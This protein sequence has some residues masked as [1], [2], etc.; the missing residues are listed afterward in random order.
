V[1]Q[2]D[3]PL[4]GCAWL[5]MSV[6]TTFVLLILLLIVAVDMGWL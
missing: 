4:A 6:G 5:L 2:G 1:D 3:D